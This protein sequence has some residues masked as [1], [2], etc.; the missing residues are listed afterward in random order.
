MFGLDHQVAAAAGGRDRELGGSGLAQPF[1]ARAAQLVQ[2]GEAALV[3][4]PPRGHAALF[5]ALLAD[6]LAFQLVPGLGIARPQVLG[7]GL[8]MD[9][10]LVQAVQAAAV[11]P[12]GDARQ[13]V[14][15]RPVVADGQQRALEAQ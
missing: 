13:P 11:E 7:P 9:E 8:E 3:A 14:Q 5:P 1:G 4:P 2:A 12:Q 10:A 6:D 15:E